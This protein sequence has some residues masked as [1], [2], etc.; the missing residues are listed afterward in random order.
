[1]SFISP[2]P[3]ASAF[4]AAAD[5]SKQTGQRQAHLYRPQEDIEEEDDMGF[6]EGLGKGLLAGA[7][8][9]GRSLYD[10][11]DWSATKL[12]A[13][14]ALSDL[15]EERVFERP[16]TISG[17]LVE[18]IT[19][20]AL[21]LIPGL[22]TASLAGKAGTALK[23]GAGAL[24]ATKATTAGLTADF[25]SFDAHEARLSDILKGLDNPLASNAITEYLAADIDDGEFAGRM[26]N[27]IEGGV[28]GGAMVGVFKVLS[29]SVKA[30]KKAKN[31]D[32]S[33]EAVEGLA[34]AVGEVD[35]AVKEA[36]TAAAKNKE[37]ATPEEGG[38]PPTPAELEEAGRKLEDARHAEPEEGV[39]NP[40]NPLGL[41]LS[42]T[43]KRTQELIKKT[44][45]KDALLTVE[46]SLADAA[47]AVSSTKFDKA[48]DEFV[49][50][51]VDWLMGEAK[52]HGTLNGVEVADL[53]AAVLSDA[54]R[55]GGDVKSIQHFL[56]KLTAKSGFEGEIFKDALTFLTKQQFVQQA[57]TIAM[58]KAYK[59]SEVWE[60]LKEGGAP[61]SE[62]AKANK[63]ALYATANVEQITRLNSQLGSFAGKA[64]A[65]RRGVAQGKGK[66]DLMD[67]LARVQAERTSSD[68][69]LSTARE[70]DN[71]IEKAKANKAK[72]DKVDTQSPEA[73]S[74]SRAKSIEDSVTRLEELNA[75]LAVRRKKFM[76]GDKAK[77]KKRV[78]DDDPEI[79]ELKEIIR[80]Y[81]GA[82]KSERKLDSLHA[83]LETLSKQS[84]AETTA[85]GRAKAAKANK[86][87]TKP[88]QKVAD[89][90][91]G[92]EAKIKALK[93]ER[94]KLDDTTI[95]ARDIQSRKD[96]SKFMEQRL[97]SGDA[98]TLLTRIAR[99]GDAGNDSVE[100]LFHQMAAA[101]QDGWGTKFMRGALQVFT[102]NILSGP[103]TVVLNVMTPA[104]AMILRTVERSAGALLSGDMEMLKASVSFNTDMHVFKQAFK[105]AQMGL[106]TGKDIVTG[107]STIFNEGRG[108]GALDP[109]VFGVNAES[110]LGQVLGWVNKATNF[111]NRLNAA[112]DQL[113]KT[114]AAYHNVYQHY[115]LEGIKRGLK[116]GDE[117]AKYVDTNTRKMFREDGS[118][119]SEERIIQSF[120]KNLTADD[121]ADPGALAKALGREVEQ[122]IPRASQE[123]NALSKQTADYA[124][125]VTFTG[126]PGD[127]ANKLSRAKQQQP[128]IGFLLP[129]VKTP[130]NILKFGLKR[131]AITGGGT[132][133]IPTPFI[134]QK[135]KEAREQYAKAMTDV[136]R[137][138]VKGRVATAATAT[139]ALVY[140]A[141]HNG[142]KVTGGGPRNTAEKKALQATGWQPYSFVTTAADGTKTYI[143]YQRLDPFATM[144][145]IVA[146]IAEHAK[147][148]P[149]EDKFSAEALSILAFSIS[150]SLT[151]KSFLRGLNTALNAVSDPGTNLPKLFKDVGS[152]MV[153][154]MFV[155]KIKN[156]E[157][158]KMIRESRTFVDSILRKMP[159]A[160]ENVSPKR[161]FLGEAVYKQNPL[162][163]LGIFNPIY[164][165]SKKNDIVDREVQSLIHGFSTPTPNYINHPDTDMREF[166][167]AEGREAY[168]RYMEL[169]STTTIGDRNLRAALKGLMNSRFYKNLAANM[170]ATQGQFQGQ[171]PRIAEI[172]KVIGRYRRK[173]KREMVQEFPELEQASNDIMKAH[174]SVR[175][176]QSNN[177][178]PSF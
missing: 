161:T 122:N 93:D 132:L 151:D 95:Q 164:V 171:D 176:Q 125:D 128:L 134:S 144:I 165:S 109:S 166:R 140:Y 17:S 53:H 133:R 136:E 162:G 163:V 112:G 11:V 43:Y 74:A 57:Q 26:K 152:G 4:G 22:G 23:L 169:S 42:Q 60:G 105:N 54:A 10:L 118:L 27:V 64:L 143:S 73:A 52:K 34:G 80:Y 25:V 149:H 7:E 79:R 111:P 13:P 82:I 175:S 155:D 51:R 100:E 50:A 35:E 5:A 61:A 1:M 46:R 90:V 68:E 65:S 158:E 126:D 146:D 85:A 89:Q 20:F 91:A 135:S 55:F 177:P 150:E 104:M 16:T 83:E 160:E 170:E 81:D 9:F 137:A 15:S 92:I 103:P 113:N 102:G 99:A 96:F 87:K 124:Q 56:D 148:N 75:T 123:M 31:S 97:G 110:G 178:I 63:D 98:E 174:R 12:G 59:L 29:K 49:K 6:G 18:G 167:N 38:N 39:F 129:F 67:A 28:V 114:I 78:E 44:G 116:E 24:K 36:K 147:M 58:K 47:S 14:D 72:A 130:M 86:N 121:F 108:V 172:Q 2:R 88:N 139:A 76:E 120:A 19:Q 127:I 3:F 70:T 21:G 62:I 153:V 119:Y 71:V 37:G 168:D 45:G 8:G 117:L 94:L 157:G 48:T 156:V 138:E 30:L 101:T 84:P 66:E 33:D 145:G 141:G 173:A 142:D 69:F 115:T 131:S 159:I 32:G 77:K 41:G 40:N 154:P 106:K 107:G